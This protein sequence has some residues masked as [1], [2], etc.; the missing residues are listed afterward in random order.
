MKRL[1]WWVHFWGAVYSNNFD[2]STPISEKE[3]RVYLRKWLG[4]TR[5]PYKTEIYY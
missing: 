3:F 5:L 2:F 4:V 1:R